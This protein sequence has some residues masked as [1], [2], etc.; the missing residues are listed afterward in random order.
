MLVVTGV[1]ADDLG[2]RQ[3]RSQKRATP[4]KDCLSLTA[5]LRAPGD[6]AVASSIE[7]VHAPWGVQVAGNFSK[8]HA[9][10]TFRALQKRYPSLLGDVTPMILGGRMQGRGA[11]A[12]Y[13]IRLPVE[14]REA[15]EE[16]CRKLQKAGGSCIV[17]KT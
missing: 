15:G 14:T 6:A 10:E 12:F 5:L 2:G 7:T 17:L 8:A 16:L 9:V 1:S 13:R 11:R 4:T 3:R